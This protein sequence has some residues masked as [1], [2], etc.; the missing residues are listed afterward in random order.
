[1]DV[2]TGPVDQAQMDNADNNVRF[3]LSSLVVDVH[4]A[5]HAE[6]VNVTYLRNREM[7]RVKVAAVAMIGQQHLNERVVTDLP[8]THKVAMD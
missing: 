6:Q 8:D 4:H 5:D 7:Y 2:L 1:M 3:R